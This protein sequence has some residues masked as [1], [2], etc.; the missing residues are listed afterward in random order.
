MGARI[1][2]Q[3]IALGLL[4]AFSGPVHASTP[5]PRCVAVEGQKSPCSGLVLPLPE[6]RRALEC[7][8][9][10]QDCQ[11]ATKL[12]EAEARIHRQQCEAELAA[13]VKR[14]TALDTE[15]QRQL[16]PRPRVDLTPWYV[17]T[18]VLATAA[19]AL[20]VALGVVLG[21]N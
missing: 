3:A 1:R 20:G 8:A 14:S 15:L 5:P 2:H 9:S 12:A 17:A 10:L 16:K 19:V 6:V 4:A 13:E 18:G 21:A 7:S 11:R